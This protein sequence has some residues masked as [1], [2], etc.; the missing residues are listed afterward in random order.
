MVSGGLKSKINRYIRKINR[1]DVNIGITQSNE[2]VKNQSQL[3]C[4]DT[5]YRPL[6]LARELDEHQFKDTVLD[7]TQS[8]KSNETSSNSTKERVSTPIHL[9]KLCEA[10]SELITSAQT[11]EF[12][13]IKLSSE[14]TKDKNI[15]NT[16]S[17]NDS[18]NDKY[19]NHSRKLSLLTFA[20]CL[21]DAKKLIPIIKYKFDK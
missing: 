4:Q 14:E 12:V 21:P 16:L 2:T 17:L 1:N 5:S 9:N 19:K 7:N 20:N 6:N 15:P 3:T 8:N 13:V 11:H 18:K 10:N